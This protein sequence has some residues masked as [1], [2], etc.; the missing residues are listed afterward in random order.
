MTDPQ[1]SLEVED[2]AGGDPQII[3]ILRAEAEFI[4]SRQQ[5][6]HL[7]RAK[8][9]AIGH[10]D[11]HAATD[12]HGKR[13]VGGRKAEAIMAADVRVSEE[14]LTEWSDSFKVAGGYPPAEKIRRKHDLDSR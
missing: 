8:G 10:F 12:G 1:Y 4:E 2:Y 5:I 6:V 9:E 7:Q 14:H 11:V 13:I 3:L